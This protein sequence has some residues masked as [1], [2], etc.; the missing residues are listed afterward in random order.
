MTGLMWSILE[1]AR[2]VGALCAGRL[3][4]LQQG[5]WLP[6]NSHGGCWC[7]LRVSWRQ[8]P[9]HALLWCLSLTACSWAACL[10]KRHVESAS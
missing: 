6:K 3:P 9:L 1:D 4:P 8:W 10:P 2:L 5:G 7:G